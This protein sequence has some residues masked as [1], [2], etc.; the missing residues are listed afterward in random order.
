VPSKYHCLADALPAA[1]PH[2]VTDGSLRTIPQKIVPNCVAFVAISPSHNHRMLQFCLALL[3]NIKKL[4]YKK[5][6]LAKTLGAGDLHC[7]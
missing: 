2:C 1:K 7:H 6:N 4:W 3:K 5:E